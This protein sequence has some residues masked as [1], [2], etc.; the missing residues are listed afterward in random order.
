MKDFTHRD[1]KFCRSGPAAQSLPQPEVVFHQPT[2]LSE[3]CFHE[4]GKLHALLK[5]TSLPENELGS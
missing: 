1:A 5:N 3:L 2:M 4:N